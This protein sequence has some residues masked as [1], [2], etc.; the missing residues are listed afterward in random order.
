METN[1][2]LLRVQRFNALHGESNHC[3]S[4]RIPH[5]GLGITFPPS[6]RSP[7]KGTL[8]CPC[9]CR[10][11]RRRSAAERSEIWGHTDLGFKASFG[12]F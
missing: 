4:H 2:T 5:V 12:T 6:S 9:D 1:E 8:E 11:L 3:I 7:P 10:A